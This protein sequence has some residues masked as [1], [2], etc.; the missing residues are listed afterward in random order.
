MTEFDTSHQF[1]NVARDLAGQPDL[2]TTIQRIVDVSVQLSGAL[3][4]VLWAPDKDARTKLRAASA[5]E[6]SQT[7]ARDPHP[8]Q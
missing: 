1:A 8:R 5:G 3:T 2:D 6:A 7:P 4:A